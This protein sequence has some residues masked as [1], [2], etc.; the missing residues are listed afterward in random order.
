MG[1]NKTYF[2]SYSQLHIDFDAIDEISGNLGGL[3]LPP[4]R[5]TSQEY[6]AYLRKL[7]QSQCK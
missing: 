6:G 3:R 1:V 2:F 5:Q 7:P 4:A